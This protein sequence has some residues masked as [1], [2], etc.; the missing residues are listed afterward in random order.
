MQDNI[1]SDIQNAISAVYKANGDKPMLLSRFSEKLHERII[2]PNDIKI[3]QLIMDTPGYNV[4]SISKNQPLYILKDGQD[5]KKVVLEQDLN[6]FR[7][8]IIFAFIKPINDGQHVYCKTK[9][10]Y[11]F[12]VS[13]IEPDNQ[14]V[15]IPSSY[16]MNDTSG[17]INTLSEEQKCKLIDNI[18]LW[19]KEN[20]VSKE[21]LYYGSNNSSLSTLEDNALNRFLKLQN[22]EMLSKI[23]LPCDLIEIL[24]QSK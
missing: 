15:E 24:L 5:L 23:V 10:P 13:N 8:S 19:A 17:N 14:F 18:K 12:I 20:K 11:K 21:I 16:R 3:S 7:K 4:D 6:K 1:C 22:R 9:Y 2:L